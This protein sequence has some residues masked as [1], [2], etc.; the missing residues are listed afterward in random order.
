MKE[1]KFSCLVSLDPKEESIPSIPLNCFICL[2]PFCSHQRDRE[3]SHTIDQPLG[4]P[5]DLWKYKLLITDCKLEMM[6][7]PLISIL[8]CLVLDL[9]CIYTILCPK[10]NL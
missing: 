2:L 6:F 7:W 1:T 5:S 9:S 3:P 4:G 10:F 8:R